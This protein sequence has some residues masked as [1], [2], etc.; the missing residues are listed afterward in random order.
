MNYC[1]CL[2]LLPTGQLLTRQTLSYWP[3]ADRPGHYCHW[4]AH[5]L[6]QG[7][8]L[9]VCVRVRVTIVNRLIYTAIVHHNAAH[10]Q[11]ILRTVLPNCFRR[12]FGLQAGRQDACVRVREKKQSSVAR[13]GSPGHLM[14]GQKCTSVTAIN[15]YLHYA[16]N[17][18][19]CHPPRAV[20]VMRVMVMIRRELLVMNP[21]SFQLVQSHSG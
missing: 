16:V 10:W 6:I 2:S 8:C 3:I 19:G 15:C 7:V 12:P 20:M 21:E 4:W 18:A 11:H 14:V 13:R 17:T 5:T 1:L 9:C